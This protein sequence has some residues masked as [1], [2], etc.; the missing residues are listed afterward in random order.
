MNTS[1]TVI[2]ASVSLPPSTRPS[3]RCQTTWFTSA[4]APL[5]NRA[6]PRPQANTMRS[7]AA[8]GEGRVAES[9]VGLMV[10]LRVAVVANLPLSR[11]R[12][13]AATL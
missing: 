5:A 9:D 2:E 1:T 7:T 12:R 6:K 13:N 8:K 11:F 4:A 10:V 3:D